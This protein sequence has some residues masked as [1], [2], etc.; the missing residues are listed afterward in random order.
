MIVYPS[1][2]GLSHVPLGEPCLAFHKYDGSNLRFFW[3]RR[4]GWHRYGTRYSR[5]DLEHLWPRDALAIRISQ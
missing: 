2:A 4:A 5:D 3:S 1:I